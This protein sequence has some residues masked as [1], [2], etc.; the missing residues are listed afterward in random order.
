MGFK[1]Y[2]D[3]IAVTKYLLENGKVLNKVIIYTGNLFRLEKLDKEFMMFQ[4]G[5]RTCQ[6][7]FFWDANLAVK[8]FVLLKVSSG[9][10]KDVSKL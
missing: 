2:Y 8:T 7:E 9:S 6:V 1:G 3:E 4:M 10:K 5:S